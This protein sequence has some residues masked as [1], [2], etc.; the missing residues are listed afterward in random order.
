MSTPTK[1]YV[2]CPCGELL[3]GTDDDRL[4]QAVTDHLRAAHPQLSYDRDQILMMAY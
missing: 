2:A 1:R 4:V 3:E